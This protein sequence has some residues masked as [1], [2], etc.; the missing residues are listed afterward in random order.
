MNKAGRHHFLP[1]FY[2]KRWAGADGRLVEFSRPYGPAV[3]PRRTAP[4][5]TGYVDK[6]YELAGTGREE[7]QAIEE[8]FFRPVDDYASK[9]LKLLE[10]GDPS[11]GSSV[12]HRSAWSLFLMSLMMRMPADIVALKASYAAQWKRMGLRSYDQLSV[13]DFDR[14]AMQ[15]LTHLVDHS[16]LGKR[17]NNL[18]W[19]TVETDPGEHEYLTSDQ[20]LLQFGG[21]EQVGGYIFLPIGPHRSF[22]ALVDRRG[23]ATIRRDHRKK[24]I[25]LAN[26][27][28]VVRAHRMAYASTDAPLNFIQKNLSKEP[29]I[30]WFSRLEAKFEREHQKQVAG[31]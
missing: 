12:R 26:E 2:L 22:W 25:Q 29:H 23:E 28:V 13:A 24:M 18:F 20:P 30:S 19:F 21:M 16:A 9:A 10:T 15:L 1:V 3:K 4:A 14:M 31:K 6:L 17:L 8:H 11:M 7:A 27:L 5:G